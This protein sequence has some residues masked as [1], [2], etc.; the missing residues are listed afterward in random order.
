MDK[1]GSTSV[2]PGG[3]DQSLCSN[4][5]SLGTSTSL[6]RS[7]ANIPVCLKLLPAFILISFTQVDESIF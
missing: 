3:D 7:Q 1:E 6:F 5:S 4:P 2:V